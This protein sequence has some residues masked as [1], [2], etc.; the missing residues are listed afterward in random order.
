VGFIP[1]MQGWV[2]IHKS[3]NV[4]QHIK[5]SKDKNHFI[6]LIDAEKDFDKMQH[7]SM[8]KTLMK[9]RI[10]GLYLNKIKAAY[11]MPIDNII[12]NG[13]KLKPFPLK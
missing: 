6:I 13:E 1:R 3:L 8:I 2:N 4:I 5:R 10:E 9:L 7:P 12:I 11:E